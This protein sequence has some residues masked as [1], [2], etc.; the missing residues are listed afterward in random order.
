M[1]EMLRDAIQA[2]SENAA[3][4]WA[5]LTLTTGEKISGWVESL[6]PVAR[7]FSAP[8]VTVDRDTD[9]MLTIRVSAVIAFEYADYH[10]R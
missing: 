9:Y 3:D 8:E 2:R 4:G 1:I 6:V 5:T 7:G 10:A